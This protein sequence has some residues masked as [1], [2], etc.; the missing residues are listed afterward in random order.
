[1]GEQVNS[2]VYH[3]VFYQAMDDNLRIVYSS[4]FKQLRMI[5]LRDSDALCLLYNRDY[6]LIKMSFEKHIAKL[7]LE[8]F[9]YSKDVSIKCHSYR[10]YN[11]A[12]FEEIVINYEVEARVA[13]NY[14][15]RFLVTP[16]DIN[17]VFE[18]YCKEDYDMQFIQTKKSDVTKKQFLNLFVIC[19]KSDA[20]KI[21]MLIYLLYIDPITD[22]DEKMMD[23]I[24]GSIRESL[25][26][27]EIKL[28]FIHEHFDVLSIQQLTVLIDIYHTS[29]HSQ[30]YKN[31][32]I[33]NQYNTIKVALL[34]YR[35]CWKIE[36]K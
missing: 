2:H 5:Q 9:G 25:R 19:I 13:L 18:M 36:Q 32:P 29:L 27:H 24:I 34:I 16:E 35:I 15:E 23:V 6:E 26:F 8:Q 1:M 28:F 11:Q 31:H 7:S 4:I 30:D 20:V 14:R 3:M 12:Y 22:I 10:K 17:I 21:A 33:V